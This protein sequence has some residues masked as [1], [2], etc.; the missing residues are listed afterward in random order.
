MAVAGDAKRH[1]EPNGSMKFIAVILS[2]FGGMALF[3]STF[4]APSILKT[5]REEAEAMINSRLQQLD[6]Y[7][8]RQ[9]K[10]TME[11]LNRMESRIEARLVRIEE[12]VTR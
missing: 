7:F 12:K 11:R 2:V 10:D 4:L 1:V 9:Q 6:Q 5:A 8:A 3:Y